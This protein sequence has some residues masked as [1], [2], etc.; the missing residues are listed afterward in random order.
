MLQAAIPTPVATT[1]AAAATN[2]S[3]FREIVRVSKSVVLSKSSFAARHSQTSSTKPDYVLSPNRG[4]PHAVG[5]GNVE[6]VGELI[7]ARRDGGGERKRSALLFVRLLAAVGDLARRASSQRA[8]ATYGR[9]APAS[10]A[11]ILRSGRRAV[12]TR[13]SWGCWTRRRSLRGIM[14][15][16]IG[17]GSVFGMPRSC[18]EPIATTRSGDA[19]EH[20]RSSRR[21]VSRRATN[22][23]MIAW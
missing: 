21:C 4:S 18:S 2:T 1:A 9:T 7:G 3:T 16:Y 15:A 13:S 10:F 6:Q 11:S 8:G 17:G 23:R 14:H 19:G 22:R 20:H 5:E 12:T